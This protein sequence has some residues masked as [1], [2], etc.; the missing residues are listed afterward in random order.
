M[1]DTWRFSK[2]IPPLGMERI[3]DPTE[4]GNVTR[5]PRISASRLTHG[6]QH[7]SV[8]LLCPEV[9]RKWLSGGGGE[10]RA[11]PFLMPAGNELVGTMRPII[12]LS[13]GEDTDSVVIVAVPLL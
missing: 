6:P 11:G 4:Q 13:G 5:L 12:L 8:P 3:Q 9:G 10:Q 2:K 1:G 7:S